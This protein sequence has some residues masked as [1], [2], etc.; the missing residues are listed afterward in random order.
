MKSVYD[1]VLFDLDGTLT[2]SDPGIIGSVIATLNK[3]QY[4]I[5]QNLQ[6]FIGPSLYVSFMKYCNMTEEQAKKAME[7]YHDSYDETGVFN[8]SVYPDIL[9]LLQ[10]LREKGAKVSVATSKPQMLADVVLNYFKIAPLLD[11]TFG[12]EKDGHSSTKVGLIEQAMAA[13]KI[14]KSRTVMIGDT[15]FDAEGAREAGV[16]FIG[17]LYGY[18]T[19]AE[20]EHQ[21]AQNFAN[22][23]Q[24]LKKMLIR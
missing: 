19:Q 6:R 23:A 24:E 13:C 12:P 14:E 18:G 15:R 2:K 8:N 3:M 21:G 7:I 10:S 11:F 16:D 20:M 4:P 17:V 1:L 5:P 22:S 9:E